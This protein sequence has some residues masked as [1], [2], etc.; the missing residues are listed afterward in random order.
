MIDKEF[1]EDMTPWKINQDGEV[2]AGFNDVCLCLQS[3]I[4]AGEESGLTSD[5]DFAR[6]IGN[7]FMY[8][9]E[10]ATEVYLNENTA[11]SECSRNK[12]TAQA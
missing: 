8:T 3:L 6:A 12:H 5:A 7:W 4:E 9:W 11:A 10:H 2:S 1:L